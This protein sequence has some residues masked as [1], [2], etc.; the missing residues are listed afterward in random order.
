[1]VILSLYKKTVAIIILLIMILCNSISIVC[2]KL[3]KDASTTIELVPYQANE[4]TPEKI[5]D[6]I[7]QYILSH[8]EVI[9]ESIEIMQQKQQQQEQEYFAGAINEQ[10]KILHDTHN[11]PMVGNIHGNVIITIFY[12]YNCKYCKLLNNIVNKLIIENEDIKIIWVP[13]AILEGLSEHAAK[14]ALAVYEKAPSKFHIFHNKIM[15]LTKVTLQDIE[16][17]LVEAEIDVDKV[18]DLTNSPNI[19][20]ILSMINNIASKCNLNGVPLTVIGNRVYTGLVDKLQ[21][22]VNEAR[23]KNKAIVCPLK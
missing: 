19:Q 1:M 10:L 3:L 5:N 18:N 14:I 6:Q 13:L 23:E 9:L 2:A 7:R 17:I 21:Q 15:S 8:P 16:N 22:G 11:L 20:N 4:L 12:D